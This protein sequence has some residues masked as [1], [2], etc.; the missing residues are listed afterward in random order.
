MPVNQ[1]NATRKALS[2]QQVPALAEL[3]PQLLRQRTGHAVRA[4]LEVW[5]S[6]ARAAGAEKETRRKPGV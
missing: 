3:K 5:S 2:A 1:F 6:A 4:L